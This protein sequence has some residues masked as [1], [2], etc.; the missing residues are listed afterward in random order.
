MV[1][2]AIIAF[3]CLLVGLA[4]GLFIS[5]LYEERGK[6]LAPEKVVPKKPRPIVHM[7]DELEWIREQQHKRV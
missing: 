6:E 7:D 2:G 4:S 5:W 3:V 1:A